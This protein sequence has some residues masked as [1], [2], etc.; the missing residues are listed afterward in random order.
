MKV[1]GR[2]LL[3]IN[4]SGVNGQSDFPLFEIFDYQQAAQFL[5]VSESYLRRLKAQ[6]KVPWIQIGR[7]VRFRRSSLEEWVRKREIK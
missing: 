6:G 7:A 1:P 4:P 5:K 2:D 3:T